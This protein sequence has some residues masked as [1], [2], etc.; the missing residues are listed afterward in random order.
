MLAEAGD[1]EDEQ[2]PVA[3]E[4]SRGL[5]VAALRATGRP[6]FAINPMAVARYRERRTVARSKSDHADAL[7]LANI[8]RTDMHEHRQLPADSELAQAVAV[9]ARAHQDTVWRRT[10]ATQELRA[11]L[12]EFYPGFL[13]ALAARGV[14]NLA[15][16]DARAVL[17]IAPTP[18]A[19]AKLP[20][21]RLVTA[22]RRGG[23]QRNLEVVAAQLQQL[24]RQPQLHQLH[25]VEEA[26]GRQ[27]RALLAMLDAACDGVA[28]LEEAITEAFQQ[29]PDHAVITSFPGLGDVSGARVLAEVGDD[30]SRFSDA[31]ALKAYAGSAPVTRASGR[32]V[33]ITHRRV[34]NDRLAAA[35]YV[36]AFM[37][38][39]NHPPARAHY[40]RRRAGGDRHNAAQRHL[41][42]RM[43]GQLYPAG[44][45]RRPDGEGLSPP[46]KPQRLTAHEARPQ[47][48]QRLRPRLR[49]P[50]GRS[51][52]LT[53][54]AL[55]ASQEGMGRA[56]DGREAVKKRLTDAEARLRRV[57]GSDRG[58]RRS[59]RRGRGDQR[60]AGTAHCRAGRTGRHTRTERT[61]R[62]RGIRDDR[63]AGRCR[64]G[65]LRCPAGEPEPPLPG[66]SSG[67]SLRAGRARRRC[68][69]FA[70]GG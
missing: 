57:P 6:V 44:P 55:V 29:H 38:L 47:R 50:T 51:T 70:A 65:A 56:S 3:I 46:L 11:V 26:M 63:L 9:L 14:T 35:G 49:R 33:S 43:L 39:T 32:S 17:A 62:G 52:H 15:S 69:G 22:L 16:A 27:V 7:A 8:L 40:D 2:I 21:T 5:L 4:T 66:A 18:T 41:F 53:T 19:G 45:L 64:C 54:K 59:R 30:R 37:A 13:E 61:D 42:N 12:R 23:R 1:T 68:D 48:P 20:K 34:K 58:R 24:L 60:G 36:W 25:Q 67:T 10:K 31:R 28:Q